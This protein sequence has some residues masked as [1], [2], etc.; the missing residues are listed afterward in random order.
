MKENIMENERTLTLHKD[1]YDL[2]Y[3]MYKKKEITL[4]TGVTVLC[5][6][7]GIGKTTLLHQIIDNLEEEN[8]PYFHF[9]NLKDGGEYARSAAGFKGDFGFLSSAIMS[10]EGE[11]IWLNITKLAK[12]I[13]KF[14]R[15]GINERDSV[16]FYLSKDKEIT[17]KERWILFDAVDSG[18]SVDNIVDLKEHLFETIFKYNGNKYDIYIVVVANEYEMARGEQCFD[19][20]NGKYITFKTYEA[21]RKFVLKSKENKLKR[22]TN[23]K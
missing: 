11:N 5:G 1:Y 17:S 7:N 20:Y 22:Q 19:V 15:T 2:G 10:S 21:Y 6:C 9:D 23:K 14:I 13:G 8:I 18:L 16:K 4:K 12:D 3:P